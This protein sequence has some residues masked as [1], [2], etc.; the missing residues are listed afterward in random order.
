MVEWKFDQYDTNADNLLQMKE[1]NSLRRL[2]KKFIKPRSC[3]KRFL[4][5]CDPDKSKEIERREWSTCLGVELNS[6]YTTTVYSSLFQG[7]LRHLTCFILIIGFGI[8]LVFAKYFAHL[9][10][11]LDCLDY[12]E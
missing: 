3:A 8:V 7:Q 12:L 9:D 4:K 11:L 10:A 5:F 2:V 1:V 6:E